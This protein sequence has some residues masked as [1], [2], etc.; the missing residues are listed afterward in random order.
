MSDHEQ[1]MHEK[2]KLDDFVSQKFKIVGV[3]EDLNGAWLDLEHP[4]GETASLHL[5]TANARKYFAALLIRQEN[6]LA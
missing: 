6:T 4:G 5:E 1:F 3:K 2:K